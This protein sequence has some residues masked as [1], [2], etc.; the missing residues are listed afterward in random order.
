MNVSYKGFSPNSSISIPAFL[1]IR[2]ENLETYLITF[3][4]FDFVIGEMIPL[5]VI[6]PVTNLAGVISKPKFADLEFSGVRR[7]FI[8]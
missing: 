6:K 2:L 1:A 5:S 8:I 3:F 4:I 7:T